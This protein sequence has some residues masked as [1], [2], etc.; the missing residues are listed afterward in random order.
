M[1]RQQCLQLPP[2]R[3][4]QLKPPPQLSP[5]N[6]VKLKFKS[7]STVQGGTMKTLRKSGCDFLRTCV[8]NY[9][10]C[11][12]EKLLVRGCV[13]RFFAVGDP[14]YWCIL[15]THWMRCSWYT[16]FKLFVNTLGV[17]G[18]IDVG[19]SGERRQSVWESPKDPTPT[20]LGLWE[21]SAFSLGAAQRDCNRA[22]GGLRCLSVFR[23]ALLSCRRLICRV[24]KSKEA[25]DT[26][27]SQNYQRYTHNIP[28]PIP[29]AQ[30]TCVVRLSCTQRCVSS[31][32]L[33]AKRRVPP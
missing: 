7:G 4:N 21:S 19:P 18:D 2:K 8:A 28:V 16:C 1:E 33:A 14:I 11:A 24:C 12:E 31:P 26:C 15:Q 6:C 25:I 30:Y 23:L 29:H 3:A 22:R 9:L 10:Q 13:F 20:G 5:T 32:R 17:G 27:T